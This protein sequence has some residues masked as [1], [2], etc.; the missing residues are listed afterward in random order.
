[1]V[2]KQTDYLFSFITLGI[3]DIMI[4][5][6][7]PTEKTINKKVWNKKIPNELQQM[8]D[9]YE[10]LLGGDIV[11]RL[12]TA[13]VQL[14]P[15]VANEYD[16]ASHFVGIAVSIIKRPQ[17]K[18]INILHLGRMQLI[19]LSTQLTAPTTLLKARIVN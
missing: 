10:N 13:L 5:K 19:N 16:A 17:L 18:L 7:L 8:D 12:F 6:C 4:G 9:Y 1:M 14:C 11:S 2:T 3:D 15:I